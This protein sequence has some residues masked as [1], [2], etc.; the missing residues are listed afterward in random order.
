M[1]GSYETTPVPGITISCI[2]QEARELLDKIMEE[3]RLYKREYKKSF[4][5]Y[6]SEYGFAYWLVR[7]SGLIEPAETTQP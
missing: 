1:K 4:G 5:K 7:Y 2:S 6:P 3:W